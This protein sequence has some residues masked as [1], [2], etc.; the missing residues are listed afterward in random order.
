ML[1][2]AKSLSPIFLM[3]FF[4]HFRDPFSSPFFWHLWSESHTHARSQEK[5]KQAQRGLAVTSLQPQA[6]SAVTATLPYNI[7]QQSSCK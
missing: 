4:F 1:K 3:P 2:Q 7:C 6:H 5:E